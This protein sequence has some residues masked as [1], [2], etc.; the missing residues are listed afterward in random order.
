MLM[1][2]ALHLVIKLIKSLHVQVFTL[3]LISNV[4]ISAHLYFWIYFFKLYD[5]GINSDE[6]G[7]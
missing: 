5:Q 4:H 6:I 2:Y 7:T 1:C 3:T